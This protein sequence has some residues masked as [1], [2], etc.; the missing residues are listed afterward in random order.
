MNNLEHIAPPKPVRERG[1]RNRRRGA[2]SPRATAAV[3]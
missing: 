2:K 3:P 1:G